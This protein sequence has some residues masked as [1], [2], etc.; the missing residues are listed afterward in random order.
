VREKWLE[1][2]IRD[3]LLD[4]SCTL[5]QLCGLQ[6]KCEEAAELFAAARASFE[7]QGAPTGRASVDFYEARMYLRRG[8]PGDCERATTLL[9]P[10]L[11]QFRSLGMTGWARRAEAMLAAATE[12]KPAKD[13]ADA[14]QP[15]QGTFRRQGTVWTITHQQQ[16]FGLPHARGLTDLQQLLL[17]PGRAFHVRTLDS[18]GPG[19]PITPAGRVDAG[20]SVVGGLGDAGEVLDDRARRAYRERL[21]EVRAELEEAEGY[22]D[23]GRADRLRAEL[24]ALEQELS[25]AVGLGGHPRRARSDVD[26]RRVAV[27]KRIRAAIG[28]I[29]AA[30]PPLGEHL[31]ASVRTGVH[32]VYEPRPEERVEW[33]A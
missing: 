9:G 32:C 12:R 19:S 4:A 31:Q 6:G 25:G 17:H 11:E 1:P 29:A 33:T 30:C 15:R 21:A 18:P 10:A 3:V 14:R 16:T 23:L 13:A 20:V 2:D 5:A 27:T 22:H 28:Q 26:R 8:A 24:E 7:E